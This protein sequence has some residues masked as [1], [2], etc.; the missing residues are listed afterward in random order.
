MSQM[1][2]WVKDEM[3]PDYV[4]QI[5]AASLPAFSEEVRAEL[6][7]IISKTGGHIGVNLGV[8]ELT[9]ALY[10]VFDFPTDSL[11]WDIGHQIYIQKMLTGRSNLLRQI[12]KNGG[13]PGYAFT[14]ESE[15]ERVT[16]SHAGAS[17][18]LG[19]G[20]TIA[21][22]MRQRDAMSIAVI[23]DGAL[24]EGS[25]Q[26]AINHLAVEK[27]RF[28]VVLNDN[29]I[30]LDMNFGGLHEYLRALK[31]G[32]RAQDHYFAALG[33]PFRG[34]VDGHDVLELVRVFES[35]RTIDRPTFLHVKTVKGKG[36][37][38][39]AEKS[40]VRIH[41]NWPF[42]P[43]TGTNTEGPAAKSY[44]AFTGEVIDKLL[45][46]DKKAV[47]VTPATLQNTATFT[48]FHNHKEKS[49]DVSLAEQHSMALAGGFALEGYK[50]I[51]CFEAT[52]LPRAFDQLIHD[53]C[54]NKFPVLILAARSGH[55]GLDHLTH[56][57]LMDFAYLRC[58]PNLRVLFPSDH[59]DLVR[60]VRR[61]YE[62]LTMPTLILYPYGN[63][64]DDPEPEV[65]TDESPAFRKSKDALGL[66]V[67]SGPT[68]KNGQQLQAQLREA[69]RVFDQ[70]AVTHIAP[71][72]PAVHRILAQYNYIVTIEEA[73][74]EAGLGALVLEV[75]QEVRAETRMTDV[76]R[77]G[78][79]RKLIEHGTR[80]Y[81]H[82][83]YGLDAASV[84]K[85]M[86]KY[87][88]ELFRAIRVNNSSGKAKQKVVAR[89]A[90][91][92]KPK[93][94]RVAAR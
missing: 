36:L 69:G 4:K 91:G 32:S 15:Y 74:T 2:K 18:S 45:G 87:W 46:E 83:Q 26:E 7:N 90:P 49:F 73:I 30:A 52:F 89:R 77:V 44:A 3:Y 78:F 72:L 23:G 39:M 40:P 93:R 92:V 31:P 48:A 8:V 14:D 24:V 34:P 67:T 58:V 86:R 22:R 88:P 61:E 54:T 94:G 65:L 17:L 56:M 43:A 76:L 21:N 51:V 38:T 33:I 11:I 64:L 19:L 63:L 80:D 59:R 50:P 9:V 47:L 29:E 37:E 75:L 20:V 68:N 60:M 25:S 85:R 81:I 27:G 10:R 71:V 66:I 41:W 70:I 62:Q 13:S 79:P 53:V 82:A 55:T 16:S 35:L 28:L 12:R 6:I 57:S 42:D 1:M 5:P 84:H